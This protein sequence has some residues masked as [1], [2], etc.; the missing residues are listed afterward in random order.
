MCPSPSSWQVIGSSSISSYKA[1][2][3]ELSQES[4]THDSQNLEDLGPDSC[5]E[6]CKV[7]GSLDLPLKQGQGSSCWGGKAGCPSLE[8]Q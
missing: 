1:M 6:A 2:V 5:L 4:L 7:E 3:L 8:V